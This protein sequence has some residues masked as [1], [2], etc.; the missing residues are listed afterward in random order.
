[1]SDHKPMPIAVVGTSARLPGAGNLDEFWAMIRSGGDSISEVNPERWD[2]KV[3][4][5]ADQGQVGKTYSTRGGFLEGVDEFDAAFFGVETDEARKMDPQQRLALQEAWR[6]FEDA[7]YAPDQLRG[8]KVG[9]YVG[10]RTGDYHDALLAKPEEMD[11]QTLM[12]HDTSILSARISHFLDLRGPNLTIN[13]ACSSMGVALHLAVQSLRSGEVDMALVGG[14]HIMSTPQRFLMHSRSRM[15]SKRGECRPFD[16]EADGFVLGEAVG[17]ILLKRRAD[18]LSCGDRI[19]GNILATGVRHSGYHEKG[20]SAPNP[21]AQAELMREVLAEADVT[22]S[23]INFVEAHGTGTYKGDAIE[24]NALKL[25]YGRGRGAIASYPTSDRCA[26]GSVK[27]QVGHALTAAVLPGLLKILLCFQ[28][29]QIPRQTHFRVPN[30]LIRME[31]E[32][33]WIPNETVNWTMAPDQ[34]RRAALSAF[35]YTGTNF[36][37]VLQE[38]PPSSSNSG[39]SMPCLIPLSG[40]TTESVWQQVYQLEKWITRHPSELRLADVAFTLATGRTHMETRVAFVASSMDEFLLKIR[41]FLHQ[42]SFRNTVAHRSTEET[43]RAADSLLARLSKEARASAAWY[44]GLLNLSEC[45][46]QGAMMEW[47]TLSEASAQRISLPGYAFEKHRYALGRVDHATS[48]IQTQEKEENQYGAEH[49]GNSGLLTLVFS[50]RDDLFF[51]FLAIRKGRSENQEETVVQIKIGDGEFRRLGPQIYQINPRTEQHYLS[52]FETLNPR[53]CRQVQV[54]HLWNYESEQLDFAYHGNIDRCRH[55]FYCSLDTGLRSLELLRRTWSQRGEFLSLSALFV[56]YGFQPQNGMANAWM[57][58]GWASDLRSRFLSLRLP[59]RTASCAD[60]AVLLDDELRRQSPFRMAEVNYPRLPGNP[61][62]KNRPQQSTVDRTNLCLSKTYLI[63]IGN[64]GDAVCFVMEWA[65]LAVGRIV[66]L[67]NAVLLQEVRSAIG[68]DITI[69]TTDWTGAENLK[70]LDRELRRLGV[71]DI[72]GVVRFLARDDR[73]D[74]KMNV[75][76]TLLLDELT[77]DEPLDFFLLF[78]AKS[79]TSSAGMTCFGEAFTELRQDMVHR[80]QR[81]GKS[82]AQPWC[83]SLHQSKGDEVVSVFSRLFEVETPNQSRESGMAITNSMAAQTL[84][85]RFKR[86]VA[87]ALKMESAALDLSTPLDRQNFNSIIVVDVIDRLNRAFETDLRP[88]LFYKHNNLKG[89]LNEWLKHAVPIRNPSANS[90]PAEAKTHASARPRLPDPASEIPEGVAI[91]GLSAR[92]PMAKDLQEFWVNLCG[93]RDCIREIPNDRWDWRQTQTGSDS[94]VPRWGGFIDDIDKF[95]PLFFGISAREA[96]LMDPQQRLIL[97]CAWQA[98]EDAGYDPAALAGTQTGVF[99]GVATCDYASILDA[100]GQ[101]EQAHSPIGLFHSILANRVSYLLDLR[102][103]S[104]PVDTACSSSLVAVHRAVQ[105]IRSGQ[106]TQALVGGVNAL[107]TSPLFSA[108]WQAGML[109]DDGRCKAFDQRANGYVRGEGVGVLFLK[110]LKQARADGDSIYAVIRASAEGHGGHSSSLTA[111]NSAAQADVLMRA[112]QEA[113]IDPRTIGYIETHGTGTALGDPIE[114]DGLKLTFENLMKGSGQQ[115]LSGYCGI[116]SVKTSIGHLEAAAGVAGLI[117]V[118]MALRS[119]IL[120]GNLHFKQLNPYITLADSPFYIVDR[121]QPW[122]AFKDHFGT[123][124]PRRAGVSSFG[125][126]GV[127]AHVVVEEYTDLQTVIP[128]VTDQE[129]PIILSAK[130]AE[131]LR[132]YASQLLVFLESTTSDRVD[133][134]SVRDLAYTLQIGRAAMEYR[135]G[136]VVSSIQSLKTALREFLAG[137]DVAGLCLGQR[138]RD[139]QVLSMFAADEALKGAIDTW[140]LRGQ[141]SQLMELWVRGAAID[142]IRLYRGA[143]PTRIHLPTYPFARERYWVGG[144]NAVPVCSASRPTQRHPCSAQALEDRATCLL[145]KQWEPCKIDRSHRVEG[146]VLILANRETQSL[147]ERLLRYFPDGIIQDLNSGDLL[148]SGALKSMVACVDLTGCVTA[149][150]PSYDWLEQIQQLVEIA[151]GNSAMFLGV[152]KGLESFQNS[153]VNREGALPACLYRMLQSEYPRVRSR[154]LDIDPESKEDEQ[155]EQIAAEVLADREDV[156]ICYRNG[157]RYCSVLRGLPLPTEDVPAVAFPANHV[158]WVTGGTRGLGALCADHFARR[159]GV[160]KVVLTGR[161]ALPPRAEWKGWLSKTGVMA[162]KIRA[163]QALE[164]KG[165]EVRVLTVDL[166]NLA[167]MQRCLSEIKRD[168]GPV[169]GV[170]HCAGAVD[171]N[172]PAFIRK[173]WVEIQ[174]VLDPKVAGTEI[175]LETMKAE[176]LSFMVLFSSVSSIVPGLAVGLSDYA[177]ANAYLDYAAEAGTEMFPVIS[178]QWPSWKESGMGEVSSKAYEQGGFLSQTNLEALRFLDQILVRKMG[179][180]VMP[181]V[182]NPKRWVPEA[183]LR[184]PE[185]RLEPASVT[186]IAKPEAAHHSILEATREWLAEIFTHELKLPPE[187]LANDVPLQELGLDSILLAQVWKRI[188][189]KLGLRMDPSA[190]FEYPTLA[191]LAQWMVKTHAEALCSSLAFPSISQS[192][193]GAA[194]PVPMV[195]AASLPQVTTDARSINIAVVG[196]ACRFP[197]ADDLDAYWQLVEQGRSAISR[198][199]DIRWSNPD[200]FVAGLMSNVTDFDPGYFLLSQEDARVMDPQAL[201]V[202]E[203][204]LNLFHHAGY[205]PLEIK[206]KAIG[207][208]LGA[209]THHR[210]DPVHLREA[211]NPIL[212]VGQNYLA[213]NISRFFDLRGPSLVVDTACS[214]ALVGMNLAVQALRSGDVDAAIVGGVSLLDSDATHRLFHQR[215]LLSPS[216]EFH[217]FDQRASGVVLGE[218]VGMVL[219]KTVEKA[220]EDGDRIYGVIKGLAINNDGRSVGPASPNIQAQK[221]VM[222]A[223]LNR[224][225]FGP[226]E[227][228]YIEANGSGSEITDLIELKAIEAIYGGPGRSTC[229]IGSIKPNIGHPLCAEGIAGFIKLVLML[230]RGQQPLFLSGQMA[231]AHYSFESSPFLF[232]RKTVA[233]NR[234]SR[235]VALNCFADGGTNAHVVLESWDGMVGHHIQRAPLARPVLKRQ[236]LRHEL[237]NPWPDVI[238]LENPFLKNHS[239]Y[240]QQLLPGLAYID[241]LY[242]AFRDKGYSPA[243]LE[244]RN[245]TIHHPMIARAGFEMGIEIVCEEQGPDSWQVRIEGQERSKQGAT[246]KNVLY[247]TAEMHRGNPVIFENTLDLQAIRF[248]SKMT[249]LHAAYAHFQERGLQHSGIMK[250]EGSIYTSEEASTVEL[251]LP[252]D[253]LSGESAFLFHPTL[254]DGAAVGAGPLFEELLGGEDRLFLPLHFGEFR[255]SQPFRGRCI[256]RVCK[257]SLRRKNE[258]L[259]SDVEF[260]N[261]AGLKVAELKGFSYKL[262][263]KAGLIH[264]APSSESNLSIVG[265][266][267]GENPVNRGHSLTNEVGFGAAARLIQMTIGAKLKKSYGALDLNL[268]YY[269]LGLDSAMLL[270]VVLILGRKLSRSLSPTLLF[271]YATPAELAEHLE[272]TFPEDISRLPLVDPVDATPQNRFVIREFSLAESDALQAGETKTTEAWVFDLLQNRLALWVEDNHLKVRAESSRLT[273]TLLSEIEKN[274]FGIAAFVGNRKLLP[275]TRSQR[276]YWVMTALQPEKAAYNNPIGMRLR[277]EIEVERIKEAFLILMNTHHILRSQYPRMGKGPVMVIPP[278]LNGMPF[279]VIRL[280]EMDF[281]S[282]ERALHELAV[283][284]SQKPMHPAH[285]PTIRITI[286]QAAADDITI[287]LTAHHTVFDGYSYLPV[288]SE[289]MRIYRAVTGEETPLATSLVQYEEYSLKEELK[290]NSTSEHFWKEHLA[291]APSSVSLPLD[292]ERPQVNRGHGETRSI[293]IHPNAFQAIKETLQVQQIT[294]FGFMLTTLKVGI[295]SWSGQKDLVFGTT[296]QCRDE[297]E[298]AMVIGDFTNFIPIRTHITSWE[299]FPKLSKTV[300]K[301]SLL[302]LQ[303]KSLPFDD[304]V[305]LAGSASRSTNPVYNILVNQLPSITEM[306]KS[307]SDSRRKV[308]VSNNRVLNK[309]AMLDMRF[310]WYEEN[311]GLRLICEYNTDL[312]RDQ[313]VNRFLE[314]IEDFLNSGKYAKDCS[315]NEL[316]RFSSSPTASKLMPQKPDENLDTK[317]KCTLGDSE[318]LVI[319]IIREMKDIPDLENMKDVSFFELGLGSFD[320]ANLSAALEVTYPEFVVG[321]LFKYPTIRALSTFLSEAFELKKTPVINDCE[322]ENTRINFDLFRA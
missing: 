312:F 3:Y 225:G 92:F 296:V 246:R 274:R 247:V 186:S 320:V 41:T 72:H 259:S 29:R 308:T 201:L 207:V 221:A 91:V 205:S 63:D 45:Y 300:Y 161:D 52:L 147:A 119:R 249:P 321:D 192:H 307:L 231:P 28:H 21:E 65:R 40:K 12:G 180:V 120:P 66:V 198:V 109:A 226:S 30:E 22:P 35:S 295:A 299:S 88:S 232:L 130:T 211:R 252:L 188:N 103:P 117:K 202:L 245:L 135:L 223:A 98:I 183:L 257:S 33:L 90:R 127:N 144:A 278:S 158:L 216:A 14:V 112:Y 154:H 309:S 266:S 148:G 2:P 78:N 13:T 233:W 184:H 215:N 187:K 297:D 166:T 149:P 151:L 108:F 165:I 113:G 102:G 124:L 106:C 137:H 15:L 129:Y 270:D 212:A 67:V 227:V 97:Q 55:L 240:G 163:I 237:S 203:E 265:P 58:D 48:V 10:A 235:R 319:N 114:I 100:A 304:I 169:G 269:D 18:A 132:E 283:L 282:K 168:L 314:I 263:R 1:M 116:G 174:K 200:G 19:R 146:T 242:Q 272:K 49:G 280:T 46:Q 284:E 44:E 177:M 138:R 101:G 285:G 47:G 271:E 279:E 115:V 68:P 126:G 69:M 193:S 275:L 286:V 156:E 228:E 143:L 75:D 121:T 322:V 173:P 60:L 150:C 4:Y 27:S 142:W 9:V 254:L 83:C 89:V 7:G 248:G 219:L 255:S 273:P 162:E 206:G 23:S 260:F 164:D 171:D 289:F 104:Q 306:E 51:D 256:A 170:L 85:L 134:I 145:R 139:D 238:V 59:D 84:E 74:V 298:D 214:S 16:E 197:G 62:V 208:Y 313:T 32:S 234:Q 118:V 81:R 71:T 31:E 250:A 261:E 155:S 152:T 220:Q 199:P 93:G 82:I 61:L 73:S 79:D 167:E 50:R 57:E 218:G 267:G 182:Y 160:K 25:I 204:T 8:R 276:R 42:P 305:K 195:A 185:N 258:L 181:V 136:L 56:H 318:S 140:M 107:L 303:H 39:S 315:L 311:S 141:W 17:F 105:A 196:M 110:S 288:M 244:L 236:H 76:G 239:A 243:G 264:A 54:I 213:A 94:K 194:I 123:S 176:P 53:I 128:E 310:E 64:D 302:C 222:Q 87:E 317:N 5:N 122:V 179:P 153:F 224:S 36:H 77:K 287:L 293:W 172:N 133:R 11:P 6:T 37:M 80:G 189:Q 217:V 70:N 26:I 20:I 277:G 190:A 291:G 131:S 178:I 111:P 86:I 294:L 241:I 301:N 210:P 159:S 262:V 191:A 157:Q 175:L 229:A 38:E 316:M 292:W 43:Q 99:V 268:G 95:D 209:R 230:D 24:A 290:G 251:S 125:F 34:L 253:A 96:E 281:E